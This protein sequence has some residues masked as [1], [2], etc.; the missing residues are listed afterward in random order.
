[1]KIYFDDTF[2]FNFLWCLH[3]V[4]QDVASSDIADSL[5]VQGFSYDASIRRKS[6]VLT[7][8]TWALHL[9]DL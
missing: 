2:T 3:E 6:F 4:C 5:S 1:M 7:F 8:S 9:R